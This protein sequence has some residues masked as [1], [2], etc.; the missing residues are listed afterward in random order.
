M[1][2]RSLPSSDI[3]LIAKHLDIDF[4]LILRTMPQ[5]FQYSSISSSS[6]NRV[7]EDYFHVYPHR[8]VTH[9]WNL[10][11]IMRILVNEMI[12]KQCL[13]VL[14]SEDSL[15]R[16]QQYQAQIK[17]SA[18]KIAIISAEIC[19]SVP[20]YT[21]LPRFSTDSLTSEFGIDP[22]YSRLSKDF[23]AVHIGS[24]NLDR[25]PMLPSTS[26]HSSPSF[27]SELHTPFQSARCYSLIFPL[28]VAGQ[29]FAAPEPLWRWV[30]NCL[31]YTL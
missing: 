24:K 28:Y 23:V 16:V 21:L 18:S 3:V 14:E 17:H 19:T 7:Y 27:W 30:I 11:R 25:P 29:S 26:Y 5:D 6:S 20:Q 2:D 4:E 22:T 12:T 10:L 8:R 13:E 9:V 1:K 31:T 15:L